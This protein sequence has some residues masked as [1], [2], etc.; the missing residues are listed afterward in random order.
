[1]HLCAPP[2]KGWASTS[3]YTAESGW[4]DEAKIDKY[5]YPPA[6]DTL[7]FVCGLPPMYNAL[8]GPRTE[9]ALRDGSV[10]HLMGYTA[11]MVAKM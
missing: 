5:C 1:M 4:V 2:P 11:D 8:C 9:R 10:L 3:T 6:D 7:L